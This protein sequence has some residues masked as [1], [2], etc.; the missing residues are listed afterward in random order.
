M[1]P[2]PKHATVRP[3]NDGE[4]KTT[5]TCPKCQ[6]RRFLVMAETFL[7]G[8]G[9]NRPQAVPAFTVPLGGEEARP[10]SDRFKECAGKLETWTCAQCGFTERYA[11][12]LEGLDLSKLAGHVRYFDAT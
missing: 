6:S 11:V 3:E 7:P 12:G 4:M 10:R 1:N 2:T 8:G 5:N 9:S